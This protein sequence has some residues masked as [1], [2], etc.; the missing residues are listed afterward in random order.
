M[1]AFKRQLVQERNVCLKYTKTSK[2]PSESRIETA[3]PASDLVGAVMAQCYLGGMTVI[4]ELGCS[5]RRQS[6]EE[7]D[8][9]HGNSIS[10]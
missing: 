5:Q 1:Q 10:I 9:F 2:D 6:L 3:C 7:G 8:G 4:M